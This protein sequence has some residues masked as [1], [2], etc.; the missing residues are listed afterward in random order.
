VDPLAENVRRH[1]EVAA[2]YDELHSEIFNSTEQQRLA[3]AL[4][5]AWARIRV[6]HRRALD[7]GAGTG[8]LTEKVLRLGGEVCAADV[9]S[10]M[11]RRLERKH[12]PA[13]EA[14]GL[15]TVT[16]DGTF[17][18]PFPDDSFAFVAAYSVLHH[19]PDYLRAVD[20]LA[21]VVAVGGV[22]YIDHELNDDHWRSPFWLR[23]HRAL[24]LPRYA[25]G[26]VWAR[27]ARVWGQQEPPLLP[28]GERPLAEEGDIHIHAD[29]HIE[30]ARVQQVA[31]ARGIGEIAT[32]DYLLCREG[33]FP[34]RHRLCRRLAADVRLLVGV[35]KPA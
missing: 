25:L 1:D 8:N 21:R 7:F 34:W 10:E 35:K 6:D 19:V 33:R 20:E 30:W 26:R 24:T 28:P 23:V 22:L 2:R 18:L 13:V 5:R 32:E 29:D 3:G 11:L 9:S 17:P 27:V 4:E 16:L 14:G 31:S 15:R 12:A